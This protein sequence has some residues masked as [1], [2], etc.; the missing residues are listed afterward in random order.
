MEQELLSL[1]ADKA[2]YG[3][4]LGWDQQKALGLL[5]SL[6]HSCPWHTLHNTHNLLLSCCWELEPVLGQS[7]QAQPLWP[8][9]QGW[10]SPSCL[11]GAVGINMGTSSIPCSGGS[12]Q[13]PTGIP[14]PAPKGPCTAS[15]QRAA[16]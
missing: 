6:A 5:N 14:P 1:C 16:V 13:D 15:T 4:S 8:L 11:V 12:I 2:F 9:A 10:T 3:I 7:I